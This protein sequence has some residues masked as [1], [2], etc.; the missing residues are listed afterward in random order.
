MKLMST[1]LSPLAWFS[2]GWKLLG[3]VLPMAL[4]CA[5][6][7][8]LPV[9]MA[10][11]GVMCA[12]LCSLLLG[13]SKKILLTPSPFSALMLMAAIAYYALVRKK[14]MVLIIFFRT[15]ADGGNSLLCRC[16]Q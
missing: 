1:K 10:I 7:A 15:N 3:Y 2:S 13:G 11:A 5:G 9:S 12:L 4:A 14:V 6:I 16:S 8:G